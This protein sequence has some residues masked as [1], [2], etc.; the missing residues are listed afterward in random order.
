MAGLVL[1]A[2]LPDG[3][4]KS[5]GE[6]YAGVPASVTRSLIRLSKAAIALRMW[7]RLVACAAVGFRRSPD[8]GATV[9]RYT[10]RP[11]C[12]RRLVGYALACPRRRAAERRAVSF[13]WV[14]GRLKHAP[15]LM[16]RQRN[17]FRVMYSPGDAR[18]AGGGEVRRSLNG[19]ASLRYRS[20]EH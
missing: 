19:D 11:K 6:K 16:R 15:P 18:G 8:A 3:V 12:P 1:R 14:A 9:G 7:G 20:P 10:Q 2:Q 4:R 5:G 13:A 17:N